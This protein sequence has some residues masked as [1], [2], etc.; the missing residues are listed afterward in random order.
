MVEVR[1]A[2]GDDPDAEDRPG[3]KGGG[4]GGVRR[5]GVKGEARKGPVA[6]PEEDVGDLA[7]PSPGGSGGGGGGVTKDPLDALPWAAEEPSPG[8]RGG[9]GG[10]GGRGGVGFVPAPVVTPR[11]SPGGNAGATGGV[12]INV[13]GAG[14][15]AAFSSPSWRMACRARWA[16]IAL[17]SSSLWYS[18]RDLDDDDDND[19]DFMDGLVSSPGA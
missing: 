15:G 1:Q 18:K 19:D 10:G 2:P 4:G 6:L 13:A 11:E 12:D 3:G 14:A 8:G 5:V 16:R 9:G 17:V 7:P